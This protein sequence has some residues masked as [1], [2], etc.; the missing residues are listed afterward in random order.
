MPR[1]KYYGMNTVVP[2]ITNSAAEAEER[3]PGYITRKEAVENV[4]SKKR[5]R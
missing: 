3:E 2:Q 5:R 4:T 1:P